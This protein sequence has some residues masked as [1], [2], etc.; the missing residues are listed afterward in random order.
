MK[1]VEKTDGDALN[2]L[3]SLTPA[4]AFILREGRE[5]EIPV[6]DLRPGDLAVLKSGMSVPAD[7][8]VTE[9]SAALDESAVTGETPR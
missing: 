4:T 6:A 8:V 1:P 3:I 9:G 5:V 7:G 2:A